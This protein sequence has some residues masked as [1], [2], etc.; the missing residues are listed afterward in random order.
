M[1]L[2]FS[3]TLKQALRNIDCSSY[4]ELPIYKPEEPRSHL[5]S[6]EV[7]AR[8][9]NA[10]W[11]IVDLLNE[12]YGVI[13]SNKY[14][15]Y[16]WLEQNKED[17]VAYFL[18]EAGS[19]SLNHSEFKAPHKFHL[20]LG[21]AGFVL[22][23]EQKGKGFNAVRV[24]EQKIKENQGRAFSFFRNCKNMVFFDNPEDAKVVYLEVKF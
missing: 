1:V 13:L 17:E 4:Q 2:H 6:D 8:Y 7:I 9:G 15:L 5:I 20:W 18:N 3:K 19:N 12:E 23:I 16:N 21:K 14:D 24:D 11:A 22:G 10:K